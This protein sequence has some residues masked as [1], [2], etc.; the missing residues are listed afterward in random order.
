MKKNAPSKT[1]ELG[2]AIRALARNYTFTS[3]IVCDP[4]ARYFIGYRVLVPYLF[5]RYFLSCNKPSTWS[6][7]LLSVGCMFP[8]CRHRYFNDLLLKSIQDGYEQVV[9]LGAGYDTSAL[10]LFTDTEKIRVFEVDHLMTQRRKLSIL[11]RKSLA[12]PDNIVFISCDIQK[13]SFKSYLDRYEFSKLKKTLVIAEGILS[14]LESPIV[15]NLLFEISGLARNIRFAFDYRYPQVNNP[16]TN[17]NIR[18]WRNSFKRSGEQYLSFFSPTD[19]T[20]LLKRNNFTI[21][22]SK[23]MSDI[24][25][26]IT[27]SI[28]VP[29]HLK[30]VAGLIVANRITADPLK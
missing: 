16:K 5:N 17:R 7:G 9:F 25:L 14:Y 29:S 30:K 22:T 6:K 18:K 2:A 1:A 20:K 19:M 12:L 11:K 24:W 8:L 10:R 13:E 15:E 28:S 3:S 4:F 21:E 26:Q 27:S 23:N